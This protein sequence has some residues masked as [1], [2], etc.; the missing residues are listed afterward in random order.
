MKLRL[1]GNKIRLRL[2]QPEV[3]ALAEVKQIHSI[4]P[5]NPFEADNFRYSIHCSKDTQNLI[6]SF[7]KNVLRIDLPLEKV[8]SWADGDQVGIE[9]SVI[10][11]SGEEITVLVEK[12]FKCLTDRGEDESQLFD[13]PD[14][15]R[16]C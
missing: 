14:K 11:K 15:F 13:N 8:K 10:G 6:V 12:D 3:L 4:L 2:S 1:L 16:D 9:E 7:E 5:I